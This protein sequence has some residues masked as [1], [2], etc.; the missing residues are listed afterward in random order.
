MSLKDMQIPKD[1]E[2]EIYYLTTEEGGRKRF[3]ASGYRGQFYYD[4][5]DW[6]APQTFIDVEKVLPGE[7]VKIYLG[8]L[9][10]EEHFGKIYEGMPFEVREGARTVAKGIVTKIIDLEQSAKNAESKAT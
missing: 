4:G 8:F 5:N 2:A 7:T 10:P 1:I 9:S 3:V 6:D